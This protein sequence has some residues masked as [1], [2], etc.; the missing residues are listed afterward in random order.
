MRRIFALLALALVPAISLAQPSRALF[1]GSTSYMPT[2]VLTPASGID[3]GI[4]PFVLGTYHESGGLVNYEGYLTG[5]CNGADA[6]TALP[7][8]YTSY[9]GFDIPIPPGGSYIVGELRL[10][11]PFGGY[12]SQGVA[13]IFD[14]FDLATLQMVGSGLADPTMPGV[15]QVQ[16][17]FHSGSVGISAIN[18]AA[19]SQWLVAGTLRGVPSTVSP[20]PTTLILLIAGVLVLIVVYRRRSR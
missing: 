20:E 14:L 8:L 1:V 4:N 12:A 15:Q 10:P 5:Y 11:L 3:V 7:G 9:F 19:G 17:G 2:L 6:C 16:V 18:A 13:E